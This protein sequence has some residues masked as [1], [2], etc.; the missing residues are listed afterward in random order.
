M[1]TKEHIKKAA[2]LRA[3]AAPHSTVM[4]LGSQ[5]RGEARPDSDVDFM[6]KVLHAADCKDSE[7]FALQGGTVS[8]CR[9]LSGEIA[10]T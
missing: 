1:A 10:A 6:V 3:E 5:A 2:Q 7:A 8:V 9:W 4:V